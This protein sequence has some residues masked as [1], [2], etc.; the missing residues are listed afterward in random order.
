MKEHP[1][2][3]YALDP[4]H[5]GAGGYRL[6]RVD[7]TVLR[8]AATGLPKLPGSSLNGAVRSA[9]LYS[10][11]DADRPKAMAYARSTLEGQNKPRPHGGGDD[12]VARIFGYA[13]GDKDG[14]SRIG[15]VAFHDADI[16]AFP[17]PTMA[18][19]RWVTT[20]ERLEAAGCTNIPS[21]DDPTRVL[22]QRSA[23]TPPR[24]NL[25]WLLLAAEGAELPFPA[26]LA[27][28]P[29]MAHVRNNLVLAHPDVFPSLVNANLETRTS[30]SIDFETGAGAEGLLFTYEAAPR[31]TLYR[32]L[33]S[34]DDNRFPDLY[35][36]ARELVQRAVDLASRLGF[37]AMTT[38]GFG[39]MQP[40]WE[41]L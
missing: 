21:L 38:R 11:S 20:P 34:F 29:G 4:T 28:Q 22:A 32:G 36:T 9:A 27:E 5:I 2:Y 37:G 41:G 7:L 30:V 13:E 1:L 23:N 3:L 19:P 24:L 33:V 35:P 16:L 39:R 6:G 15:A 40:M 17:V 14:K 25:G 10:L 8:D 26:A 31:G 12:P 18:G